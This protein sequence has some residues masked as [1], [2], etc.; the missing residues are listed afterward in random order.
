[1][2]GIIDG[3]N[4]APEAKLVRLKKR[5]DFVEHFKSLSPDD[6]REF[7]ADHLSQGNS[8]LDIKLE[9][10]SPSK[11]EGQEQDPVMNMIRRE[12]AKAQA[13]LREPT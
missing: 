11:W 10:P 5:K 9:H 6:R 1:M 3:A 4:D 13:K 7:L 2:A 8:D 12:R